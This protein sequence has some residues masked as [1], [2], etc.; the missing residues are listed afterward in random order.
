MCTFI[1]ATV[2]EDADPERIEAT[3]ERTR[4]CFVELPAP[5][6]IP[7]GRRYLAHNS[8]HCDCG[9]AVGEGYRDE[10]PPYTPD[11]LAKLRKKGWSDAKIERWKAQKL[12]AEAKDE[13]A[14][15]D[16]QRAAHRD[17]ASYVDLV[18]AMLDT[19][20]VRV[21]GLMH[22]FYSHGPGY[23]DLPVTAEAPRSFADLTE[24]RLFHLPGGV[25]AEWTR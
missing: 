20:G 5:A 25:V 6:G 18:R 21:F 4:F 24:A 16:R 13:R 2:N 10:R 1:T 7:A 19:P 15:L 9:T 23:D 17:L 8:G 12:D 14:T 11:D 3:F 22:D